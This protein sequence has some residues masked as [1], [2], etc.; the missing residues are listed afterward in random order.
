[1]A[2][3][4]EIPK[5]MAPK[6]SPGRST[7]SKIATVALLGGSLA[8]FANLLLVLIVAHTLILPLLILGIVTLL[9]AALSF[10]RFRWTPAIGALVALGAISV[11][12]G[13][14]INQYFIT[15]PGEAASFIPL[16][17]ILS[18]GLVALIAGIAATLQ[19]YRN[20]AAPAAGNVRP[21]LMSFT[22]FVV[23][24]MVVSLIVAV[25]PPGSASSTTTNGEPIVHMSALNFVQNVVLVPKGSKLRLV[26]D[27][28]YE[29]V[30]HNGFWK[31]DGSQESS[32]EQGAP[33]VKDVN[34][35]S[36]SI[37]IGPFALA[38][39]YH[40]Y[41]TI[42]ANMNLTVVVQ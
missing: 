20:P 16:I 21:L 25:N 39:V 5:E 19:N 34:V 7:L 18:F 32:I 17:I 28:R 29:H 6:R 14:P 4:Q 8:Y 26:D 41:C 15:H 38:G 31:A 24:M 37:E 23:G 30:L 1:M 22:A 10:L 40:L 35:T 36:G 42:H 13:V 27:G 2:K 12:M 3:I 33:L 11:Q 9:G